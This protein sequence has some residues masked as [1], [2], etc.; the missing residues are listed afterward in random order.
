M[1]SGD[2]HSFWANH[3]YERPE[4]PDSRLVAAEFVGTSITS[5]GPSYSAVQSVLPKNPQ[6]RFFDSRQ[7]GYLSLNL[8]RERLA[9][10]MQAISDRLD[11]HASVSTLKQFIVEN[12]SAQLHEG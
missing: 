9:V 1:L 7:R 11:P 10:K 8:T 6:I 4:D 2:Y 12:G 5:N 3:L